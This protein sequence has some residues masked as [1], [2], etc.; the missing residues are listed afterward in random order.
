MDKCEQFCVD[1]TTSTKKHLDKKRN[2]FIKVIRT[3]VNSSSFKNKMNKQLKLSNPKEKQK[4]RESYTKLTKALKNKLGIN[5]NQR[6]LHCKRTYCNK[7]CVGTIFEDEPGDGYIKLIKSK[8][9]KLANFTKIRKSFL[10]TRKS[11]FNGKKSVLNDNFFH[12][13]DKT[14]INELKKSGAI[15]GCERDITVKDRIFQ[16]F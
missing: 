13:M 8:F 3:M 2:Q 7:G 4:M 5:D 16:K 10:N 12:T 6:I 15:S 1:R 11:I 14:K 9:G